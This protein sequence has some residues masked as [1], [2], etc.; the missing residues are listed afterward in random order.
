LSRHTV[1]GP[2][3]GVLDDAAVLLT[4]NFSVPFVGVDGRGAVA[5]IKKEQVSD[6]SL[7]WMDE[8]GKVI[9]I[10]GGPANYQSVRLSPDGRR[11]ATIMT[12]Q[13]RAWNLSVLDLERG[14]R[15]ILTSELVRTSD[16]SPDNRPVWSPDGT[17]IAYSAGMVPDLGVRTIPSDG[18]GGAELLL[19]LDDMS[20]T[21]RQW[22]PDGT[23]LIF[24]ARDRVRTRGSRDQNI[25]FMV[26]GSKP[27]MLLNSPADE[28]G[29]ALSPDGHWLAY[30]SNVSGRDETYI[31]SFPG[32]GGTIPVSSG[33]GTN[34][35]WARNGT[36]LYFM[37]GRRLM[38][39]P[40]QL[41]PFQV[42]TPVR[43]ADVPIGIEIG[44]IGADGRFLVM[45]RKDTTGPEELH[46]LLNWGTSLQSGSQRF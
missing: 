7:A 28:S 24:V 4:G 29:P 37:E 45:E 44:D 21:P 41:R 31:R 32:P 38:R 6:A 9:P 25:G 26:R 17:H 20:T 23:T 19:N 18:S 5:Y 33:G 13:K 12:D 40:I 11:L 46:I 2:A 8:A 10:A 15:L 14:I 34:P 27:A 43:L 39:A 42:G 35:L 16:W 22:S 36:S 1:T 30:V 3:V